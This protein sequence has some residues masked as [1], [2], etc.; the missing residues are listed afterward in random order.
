MQKI[1]NNLL[2]NAI[3]FT[4]D[5]GKVQITALTENGH[6]LVSVE[7]NGSG[8]AEEDLRL[9]FKRFHQ[10]AKNAPNTAGT[11]VGLTLSKELAL[12]HHGDISVDSALGRGTTFTLKFPIQKSAYRPHQIGD[13][14]DKSVQP[15]QIP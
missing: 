15:S 13:E 3:K 5:E 4:A 1:L 8:I 7:D 10:S 14:T 6:V 9:I 11:G 2:S 12:L